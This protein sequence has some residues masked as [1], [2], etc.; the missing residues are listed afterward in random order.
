MIPNWVSRGVTDALPS[1]KLVLCNQT[2]RLRIVCLRKKSSCL[3]TWPI[4]S[5]FLKNRVILFWPL[6]NDG[7][8]VLLSL[9]CYIRK[10]TREIGREKLKGDWFCWRQ[11]ARGSSPEKNQQE[12]TRSVGVKDIPCYFCVLKLMRLFLESIELHHAFTCWKL[13][14]ETLEQ[15]MKYVQNCQ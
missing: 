3:K 15:G 9:F 10:E 1:R 7:E 12:E 5:L 8:L 11:F 6:I 13:T 14:I 2:Q 4:Y